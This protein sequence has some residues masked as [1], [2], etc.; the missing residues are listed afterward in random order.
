MLNKTFI[1][2]LKKDY[3]QNIKERK[4]IIS[5]A[6]NILHDAKRVIFATHRPDLKKAQTSLIDI[7]TRLKNLQKDFGYN[8]LI[9]EGA[10]SAAV[11]E[12]VEAKTFYLVTTGKKIEKIKS[13]KLSTASYLG[14]LSD[15]TGELVRQAV[16]AAAKKDF[17]Q[18]ITNQK[19]IN[20]IMQ[21][22]VEFDMT[23]YLRTKYDQARNNLRKIEQ[24][25]YEISLKG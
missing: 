20:D 2:Q 5:A 21:E 8:R 3:L 17:A 11:E 19:M 9:E 24:I 13:I 16:N 6:N 7:E 22:L 15:L 10:Y 18:V 12:Y 1:T 23:G 4:I 14:G 25:N